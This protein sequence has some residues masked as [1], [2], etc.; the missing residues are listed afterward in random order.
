MIQRS[1]LG[2]QKRKLMETPVTPSILGRL[3]GAL[4]ETQNQLVSRFGKVKSSLECEHCTNTACIS[5]TSLKHDSDSDSDNEDESQQHH[6][7]ELDF[8]CTI[9]RRAQSHQHMNQSLVSTP[10]PG[11]PASMVSPADIAVSEQYMQLK[12]SIFCEKCKEQG[13]LVKFGFTKSMPPRPRFKCNKCATLFTINHVV[14]MISALTQQPLAEQE[15]EEDI[16]IDAQPVPPTPTF[17]HFPTASLPI[18]VDNPSPA[19]TA[20]ADTI[21]FLLNSVKQLT[22]QATANQ[23]KFDY[24]TTLI[25]QNKQLELDLHKQKKENNAQ[26]KEIAQLKKL[27]TAKNTQNTEK[28]AQNIEKNTQKN[29]SNMTQASTN[30]TEI[31]TNPT[32]MTQRETNS[33]TMQTATADALSTDQFPSLAAAPTYAAQVKKHH[34]PSTKKT[35]YAPG[36]FRSHNPTNENLELASKIFND[37]QLTPTAEYKYLY[38]PSNSRMKPSVIRKKLT[39]VGVDNLRILDAHSPDW[40]VIAL[41]IHANYEAD[42]CAKFRAANVSPIQ[43]NYFDPIHL[44]DQRHSQLTSEEKV[45]KLHTIFKNNMMRALSFMRYPTC[46]SVAK[47]FHRQDMLTLEELQSFLQNSKKQQIANVFPPNTTQQLINHAPSTQQEA[48]LQSPI[49]ASDTTT[50]L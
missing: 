29:I 32:T 30:Y 44:R 40:N 1:E 41:L 38:F 7:T 35:K 25:E 33:D 21:T 8:E 34:V 20:D 9:C 31:N 27:L 16:Y 4:S 10:L 5:I 13:S 28:Q 37:T 15:D 19:P 6:R 46:H 2:S 11:T 18:L 39:L 14:D 50:Q 23:A 36:Q 24:I 22:A 43:Y 45:T 42:L 3:S 17:D 48:A 47:F 49:A 26:K 12:T